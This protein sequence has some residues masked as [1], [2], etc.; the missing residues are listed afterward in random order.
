MKSLIIGMG[1][2][3]LYYKILKNLKAEIVTVD[4]DINKNADF[5]NIES[6]ITAYGNFDTVHIC[7]PNYTHFDIANKVAPFSKLVFIE[8]PGVKNSTNWAT[9]IHTHKNT[10]FM[11]VKNNMWRDNIEEIYLATKKAKEININWINRNRIPSPGSWFTTKKYA[12]GGVS[13]DLM[14]HLLSIYIVLNRHW[15]YSQQIHAS[16]LVTWDLKDLE[17][18]DYGTVNKDGTYD[19]DD[20]C[21]LSF[22]YNGQIWNLNTNWRSL[23]ENKQNIEIISDDGVITF[24][25]GLCPEY[26]YEH[27]IKESYNSLE[28]QSFWD[29]QFLYDFWIHE[30]IEGF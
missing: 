14:P 21:K 23:E 20:V 6:A 12:Y 22:N 10:R 3:Q 30:R 2:G 15:K 8:K 11:M 7:T 28:I 1:I 27:M 24:E 17:D 26:A 29:Q 13:R 9:L 25:L 4:N 5:P 19:V 16:S 18:T